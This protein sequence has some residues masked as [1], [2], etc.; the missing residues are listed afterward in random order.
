MTAHRAKRCVVV[1]VENKTAT[2][3]KALAIIE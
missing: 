2:L 3:I 1:V